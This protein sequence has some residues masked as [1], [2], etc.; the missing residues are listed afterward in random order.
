[1]AITVSVS[2]DLMDLTVKEILMNAHPD[3]VRMEAHAQWVCGIDLITW[4]TPSQLTQDKINTYM[5]DCVAGFFGVNCETD[6]NE[7]NS[8]PCQNGASCTVSPSSDRSIFLWGHFHSYCRILWMGTPVPV[9]PATLEMTVSLTS[10]NAKTTQ[11]SAM[12]ERAQYVW[13][14]HTLVTYIYLSWNAHSQTEHSWKLLLY[15][16]WWVHWRP[17]WGR[18]WWVCCWAMWKWRNLPCEYKVHRV[19]L[20][21]LTIRVLDLFT[22]SV[23][24]FPLSLCRWLGP[25]DL[26]CRKGW[27]CGALLSAWCHLHGIYTIL[28]I[29]SH[30]IDPSPI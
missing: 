4:I 1:M 18:D 14:I 11:I 3:P 15:V 20:T 2:M 12:T 16:W 17:L 30:I 26:L 13:Y 5:C 25:A 23:E 19:L 21:Y 6:I 9:C 29:L 8:N 22:G 24:R 10:T 7:C 27:M 28:C